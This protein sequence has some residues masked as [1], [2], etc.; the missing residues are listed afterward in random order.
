MR[1][2]AV[3]CVL[4]PARELRQAR[5][6]ARKEQLVKSDLCDADSSFEVFADVEIISV[7]LPVLEDSNIS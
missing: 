6:L 4:V 1:F 2:D 5:K 3:L 7:E